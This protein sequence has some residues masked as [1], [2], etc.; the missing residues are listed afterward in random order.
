[1][2]K[3]T[4]SLQEN[5]WQSLTEQQVVLSVVIYKIHI[6]S[7]ATKS[8]QGRGLLSA[9][10]REMLRRRRQLRERTG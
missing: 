8:P 9:I 4:T 5:I 3:L 7:F 1:M 10:L 2:I 6:Q